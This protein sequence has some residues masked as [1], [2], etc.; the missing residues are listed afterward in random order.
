[1]FCYKLLSV[2]RL[3]DYKGIITTRVLVLWRLYTLDY[4]K[5][6]RFLLI[7]FPVVTTTTKY[8]CLNYSTDSSTCSHDKFRL[9]ALYHLSIW[10]TIRWT[11]K[12]GLF[13]KIWLWK[14]LNKDWLRDLYTFY[15]KARKVS[16]AKC[17]W[18]I[19]CSCKRL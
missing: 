18:E 16:L 10:P 8:A 9:A 5:M 3:L 12:N 13:W 4:R 1:M 7:L 14:C 2:Y 11:E 15:Y 6:L 19:S 17:L